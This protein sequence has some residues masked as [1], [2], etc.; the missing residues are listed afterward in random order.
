[1]VCRQQSQTNLSKNV[2]PL[3]LS[4]K[5]F[6]FVHFFQPDPALDEVID[7]LADVSEQIDNERTEGQKNDGNKAVRDDL[8]HVKEEAKANLIV[9]TDAPKSDLEES[10]TNITRDVNDNADALAVSKLKIE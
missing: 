9:T 5:H 4:S 1:M 2:P 10:R 8:E 7:N 6:R 3:I